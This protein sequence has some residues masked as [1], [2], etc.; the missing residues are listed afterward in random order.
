MRRW[1]SMAFTELQ[2]ALHKRFKVSI[3]VAQ[4]DEWEQWFNARRT[5]AAALMQAI[6]AAEAEIDA[7]VYKLFDLT[8]T[9]IA[10]IE[11]ALAVASPALTLKSYEAISAVEGLEL[12]GEARERLA[13]SAGKRTLAA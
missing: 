12:S 4:R 8:P 13:Q 10:A 7:R 6:A 3:P 5:E 1:P 2:T 11:D 9:E